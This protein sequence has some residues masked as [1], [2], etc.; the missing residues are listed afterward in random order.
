M[1]KRLRIALAG[2]GTVGGACFRAIQKGASSFEKQ[3]GRR[4][5]IVCV[6]AR[7]KKKKR[8]FSL[9]KIDWVESAEEM[10]R[11]DD[12][13]VVLELIGGRGGAAKSLVEAALQ[14]SKP[15]ITA[16]KALL[17][18]HG[19]RLA[20]LAEKNGAPLLYEAAIAGAIPVVRV[21][22]QS[23]A[24]EKID[25]LQGILNGTCNHILSE[26][27]R[28]QTFPQALHRAQREGYAEADPALD[29]DGHDAAQKLSLLSALAFK[30]APHLK[31]IEVEGI[32]ALH[33]IDMQMASDFGC[34]I[35]LVASAR[36]KG[37]QILERVRPALL[38][39]GHVLSELEGAQNAILFEGKGFGTILL[40][41]AGAGAM[42]T[43]S[44]VLSDLAELALS[45]ASLPVFSLPA[46]TMKKAPTPPPKTKSTDEAGVFY[47]RLFARDEAGSMAEI[48]RIFARAHVSL[49]RICQTEERIEDK[50]KQ[51]L[52]FAAM[53][54]K[55][56]A[57]SLLKVRE[58]LQKC[59]VVSGVPIVL[60]LLD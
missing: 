53:T 14:H 52:P 17:A 35:R 47:I 42:P 26:M 46:K 57:S 20:R 51:S 49:A 32:R 31:N 45:R 13:D 29:I 30:R 56:P 36:R 18:S 15:V 3:T 33:P 38:P 1:K 8:G 2:L 24:L 19:E 6:S 59:K 25:H 54:H 37:A 58:A 40:E 4:P 11:R 27:E 9:Q 44:A 7:D 22:R 5:Q 28:G 41:G 55:T 48:T 34:A 43:A 39:K 23:F 10:A 12:V 60:P 50:G 21:M 16:N